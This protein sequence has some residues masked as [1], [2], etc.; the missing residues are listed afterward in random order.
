MKRI[1]QALARKGSSA[2]PMLLKIGV[3]L[4]IWF[5]VSGVTTILRGH[6]LSAWTAV[7]GV[8]V[9]FQILLLVGIWHLRKW[10]VVVFAAIA[11]LGVLQAAQ[12]MNMT[13]VAILVLLVIRAIV[14]VPALVYW[15]RMTW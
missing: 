13:T 12:T 9:A 11:G 8:I 1:T 2:T 15:R 5:L 4:Q 7:F 10:A 14:L 6:S 3:A